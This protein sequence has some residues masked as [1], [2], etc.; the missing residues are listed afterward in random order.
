MNEGLD[1]RHPRGG[2]AK[3]LEQPLFQHAP[4]YLR[5]IAAR[6]LETGPVTPMSEVMED[7][8]GQ[9]FDLAPVEFY[10]LR[11]SGNPRVV[12]GAGVIVYDRPPMQKRLTEQELRAK[13]KLRQLRDMPW[14]DEL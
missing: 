12:D 6:V 2:Q 9:V 1:L 7:L 4:E 14:E 8:S 11:A 10:D 3:Y 5:D 13:G